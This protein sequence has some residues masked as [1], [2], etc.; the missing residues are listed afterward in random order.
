MARAIRSSQ[1]WGMSPH[2]ECQGLPAVY[3]APLLTAAPSTLLPPPLGSCPDSLP[4]QAGLW[5]TNL[6][7][8]VSEES[9]AGWSAGKVTRKWIVKGPRGQMPKTQ[10]GTVRLIRK[11][12]RKSVPCKL[13]L[14]PS[15]KGSLPQRYPLEFWGWPR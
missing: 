13:A 10:T 14:P 1:N 7:E 8:L 2:H 5:S 3:W 11:C 4:P 6:T 15:Y 9:G 12:Q